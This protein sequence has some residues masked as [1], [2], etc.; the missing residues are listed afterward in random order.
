MTFSVPRI[1]TA[2]NPWQV[3]TNSWK[4]WGAVRRKARRSSAERRK[5]G[6]QRKEGM[7]LCRNHPRLSFCLLYSH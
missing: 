5:E 4:D 2:S 3:R 7:S 6:E 1:S